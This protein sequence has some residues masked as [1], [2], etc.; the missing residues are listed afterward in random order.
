M[1]SRMC[2]GCADEQQRGDGLLGDREWAAEGTRG[3]SLGSGQ[4]TCKGSENAE[5]RALS[6]HRLL[7][8]AVPTRCPPRPVQSSTSPASL[9]P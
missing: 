2:R 7:L 8:T 6:A 9:K 3:A 5:A 1:G 4:W